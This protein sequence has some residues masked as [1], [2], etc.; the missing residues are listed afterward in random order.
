MLNVSRHLLVLLVAITAITATPSASACLNL[1]GLD[2]RLGQTNSV[3]VEILFKATLD[4]ACERRRTVTVEFCAIDGSGFQ[5]DCATKRVSAEKYEV[6]DVRAKLLVD[7][8]LA[9]DVQRVEAQIAS[10]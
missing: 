2:R 9:Q 4:N 6:R 5:L 1:Y 10:Y 7:R 3:Y 8:N